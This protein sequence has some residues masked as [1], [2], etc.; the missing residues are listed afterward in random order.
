MRKPNEWTYL[1][2]GVYALFDGLGVW[3]HANSHDQPTDR[4]YLEAEVLDAL[5]DFCREMAKA[6]KRKE[7]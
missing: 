1:G 2:D 4:I 5:D 3:L 6:I 7:D